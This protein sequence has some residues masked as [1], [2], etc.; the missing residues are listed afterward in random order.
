MIIRDPPA[1]HLLL[2]ELV[3]QLHRCVAGAQLPRDNPQVGGGTRWHWQRICMA[4]CAAS[5][6]HLQMP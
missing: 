4:S 2:S 5:V 1:M 6:Y 3:R